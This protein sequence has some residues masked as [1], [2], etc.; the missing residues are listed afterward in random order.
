MKCSEGSRYFVHCF[1]VR[2]LKWYVDINHILY[3][4]YAV[5]Y[6]RTK[7]KIV[8]LF[9]NIGKYVHKIFRLNGSHRFLCTQNPILYL[10]KEQPIQDPQS[11]FQYI[12]FLIRI[13]IPLVF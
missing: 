2:I 13:R 12:F 9:H 3:F 1:D 6:P 10:L 4:I 8:L 11:I 5:I 7:F